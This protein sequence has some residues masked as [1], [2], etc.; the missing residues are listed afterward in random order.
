MTVHGKI[1]FN[2][3]SL[4]G[5]NRYSSVSYPLEGFLINVTRVNLTVSL[6]CQNVRTETV[7]V[8]LY[9][10]AVTIIPLE[11][12]ERCN[13]PLGKTS[14]LAIRMLAQNVRTL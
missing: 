1:Y 5:R 11:R 3:Y 4:K 9:P 10:L 8:G 13:E 14:V 2:A 12:K 7:S 6:Q